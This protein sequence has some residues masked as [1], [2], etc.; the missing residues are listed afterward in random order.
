MRV[1]LRRHEVC[2][3]IVI[4]FYVSSSRSSGTVANGAGGAV[5]VGALGAAGTPGFSPGIYTNFE[6]NS[7]VEYKVQM[8]CIYLEPK[9]NSDTY[10]QDRAF[11]TQKIARETPCHCA[12]VLGVCI[13][14][15]S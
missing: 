11:C 3:S 9:H 8:R 5:S 12:C 7:I 15:T 2:K 4:V 13:K 10:K 6:A 1:K 14:M